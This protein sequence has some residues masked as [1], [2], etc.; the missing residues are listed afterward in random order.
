VPLHCSEN[1]NGQLT[2]QVGIH[3]FWESRLP[4]L[5]GDDYD[6]FVGHAEYVDD[7]Q[8]FCWNTIKKS[9][10]ALDSVLTFER[11]LNLRFDTDKKYAFEVRGNQMIRVYSKEYSE[12]Y[13]SNL[14][15]QVERRMQAAILSVGSIWY[16]AWVSGGMPVLQENQII[17]PVVEEEKVDTMKKIVNGISNCD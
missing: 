8:S 17:I 4:E 6:K 15:G 11:N 10:A 12:E 3:G 9:F 14:A 13:H 5:F 2:N 16:S 1:Y 7:V